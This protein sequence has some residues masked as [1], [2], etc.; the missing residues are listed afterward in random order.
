MKN[1]V[2]PGWGGAERTDVVDDGLRRKRRR[3]E[4]RS[5]WGECERSGGIGVTRKRIHLF[6]FPYV[7]HLCH[8]PF[9]VPVGMLFDSNRRKTRT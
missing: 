4:V 5:V 9:S 7:V 2:D 6:I 3:E 1:T 8:D